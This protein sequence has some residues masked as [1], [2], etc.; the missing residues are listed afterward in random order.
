MNE[1]RVVRSII[2]AVLMTALITMYAFAGAADLFAQAGK[3]EGET[4]SAEI[5]VKLSP[6]LIYDEDNL[7]KISIEDVGKY[8]G[9][10]CPCAIAGF[11]ATQLAISQL[12]RDEIPKRE[13]FK[14]ISAFP[15][16]G[17]QDAFEFI[18][19]AKTRKDFTLKLPEGTSPENISMGNWVFTIIRKSTGKQIKI[20]LKEEVFPGGAEEFF[21]LRKKVKFEKTATPEEKEAFR[22]AKQ[23]LKEALMSL[24]VDEL[25]GFKL[26]TAEVIRKKGKLA[27]ILIY[28]R[29]CFEK[30][31]LKISIE[32]IRKYRGN[33]CPGV[34][35]S[36]RA[37]QLAI[38]QL[39]KD[40]I[41]ERGDFK[42][43]S[44]AP[45]PCVRA[46]F[47]FITRVV[48]RG[49]G[50]FKIELPKGTDIKNISKD[51]F[52]FTITRKSTG[53]SIE[54]RLKEELFS[55]RFFELRKKKI[56]GKA[57]PEEIKELMSIKQKY[58]DTFM[59]LPMDKL[60]EFKRR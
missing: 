48:T 40:E 34:V 50:D 21:K 28:D 11:R 33:I 32:D 31:P 51:N 12:W 39:W 5:G 26:G 54:I 22:S 24:P 27:P 2:A 29:I 52:V 14:I 42:I 56:E 30:V 16:R 20:W 49:K 36:F 45:F 37:T 57:T 13:D 46:T 59:N 35:L 6:I 8:H 41:P 60:F 17:S 38:S 47:E 1:R 25:F 18:T 44:A 7:L 3:V 55:E 4:V 58:K 19:R 23:E 15:G 10:I 43:I 9:D 53:D